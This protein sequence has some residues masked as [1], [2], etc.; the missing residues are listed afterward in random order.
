MPSSCLSTPKRRA[1]EKTSSEIDNLGCLSR[2][3]SAVSRP[4]L[5]RKRQKLFSFHFSSIREK[6]RKLENIRYAA[7]LRHGGKKPKLRHRS[8]VDKCHII[9]TL[10]VRV[11]ENIRAVRC[12]SQAPK[13]FRR[14][15]SR[16]NRDNVRTKYPMFSRVAYAIILTRDGVYDFDDRRQLYDFDDRRQ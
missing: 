8:R 16:S 11:I 14:F 1:S 5:N 7:C 12:T 2:P 6:K 15:R 4:L 3:V 9:F 10:I 13:G